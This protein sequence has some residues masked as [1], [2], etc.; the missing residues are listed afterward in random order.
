M[1]LKK[2]LFAVGSTMFFASGLAMLPPASA[3]PPCA[4]FHDYDYDYHHHHHQQQ[5]PTYDT[6]AEATLQGTVEEVKTVSGMM[7]GRG[8]QGTH[9]MLNAGGE[10]IEVHLGPSWFLKEKNVEIAKGDTVEVI[11]ERRKI[12]ESDALLAREIHK[13]KTVWTLRDA[14]GRPLWARAYHR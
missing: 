14:Y 3:Q 11:G 10:T 8:V 7:G 9:L 2:R 12:G 4:C 5:M 6:K 1:T 13:D